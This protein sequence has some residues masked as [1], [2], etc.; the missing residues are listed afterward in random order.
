MR[1]DLR[2]RSA[3]RR[4]TDISPVL[5]QPQ[6]FVPSVHSGL[7][8][9]CTPSP[10]PVS[11]PRVRTRRI[12]LQYRSHFSVTRESTK[13]EIAK[14]Y[15]QLA[16]KYHPDLQRTESA[17]KEAEENFKRIANAYEILRDDEERSDYDYML[18]NPQEYYAH[19]YRYYRRRMAPKVDVRIVLAV[20]ITIVSIVQYFSAWQKYDTAIKYFMTVPKYRNKAIEIAKLEINVQSKGKNK[21][22]KAEQKEELDKII[23]RVIEENMDIKGAYAK[24][25]VTDILWVQLIILPFTI[26]QYIFWKYLKLGVHQ[27]NA[28]DQTE[29]EQFLDEELWIKEN[30]IHWKQR[31]DEEAK[32]ALAENN[33]PRAAAGDG[34][35]DLGVGDENPDASWSKEVEARG[36]RPRAKRVLRQV[37]RGRP[38]RCGQAATHSGRLLLT[39]WKAGTKRTLQRMGTEHTTD[40]GLGLGIGRF[41]NGCVGAASRRREAAARARLPPDKRIQHKME[42][43]VHKHTTSSQHIDTHFIEDTLIQ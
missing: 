14:N 2:Q 20:T 26:S 4:N 31:K 17:K 11:A 15:R 24:P 37:S 39:L 25:V 30:F 28:I 10:R 23:R 42:E 33:N 16:R 38:P 21:K 6:A 29:K 40:T 7:L 35:G 8:P 36:A 3:Q 12:T 43:R 18:D 5:S 22:S 9:V 34:A 1:S 19:Y 27:F 41:S 32:K 13:N